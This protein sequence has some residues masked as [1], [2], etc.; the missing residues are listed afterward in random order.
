[1]AFQNGSVRLLF[2]YW[3]VPASS[4]SILSPPSGAMLEE[5]VMTSDFN[6]VELY[7]RGAAHECAR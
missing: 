6:T 5:R 7:M 1:M 4:L 3:Q 2:G